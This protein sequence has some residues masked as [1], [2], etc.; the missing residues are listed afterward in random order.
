MVWWIGRLPEE[1]WTDCKATVE[2]IVHWLC[3]VQFVIVALN[4]K[5]LELIETMPLSD[6][7]RGVVIERQ[8]GEK[9][10]GR[11]RHSKRR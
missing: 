11:P 4:C 6:H 8:P 9:V 1:R 7:L 2:Y 3:W 5:K 10:R